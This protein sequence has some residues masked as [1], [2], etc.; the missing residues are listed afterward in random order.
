M[1]KLT[2]D[3]RL[4]LHALLHHLWTKDVGTE[5]YDKKK[6]MKL[7]EFILRLLLEVSLHNFKTGP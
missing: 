1:K 2:E 6:W 7:E 3:E 4:D 5:G